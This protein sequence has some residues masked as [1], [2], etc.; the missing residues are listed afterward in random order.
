LTPICNSP[1]EAIL[2]VSEAI[3]GSGWYG[4]TWKAK[5]GGYI[6]V[7][8]FN[9]VFNMCHGCFLLVVAFLIPSMQ[10]ILIIIY[11]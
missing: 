3:S 2:G 11:L 7:L 9:C 10:K 1:S 5:M 4:H 8:N 6:R